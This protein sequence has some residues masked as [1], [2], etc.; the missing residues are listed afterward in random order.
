M[1][2]AIETQTE[3]GAALRFDGRVA[4]VTGAGHGLGRA[5]A[6]YLAQR[7][8]AVVVNDLGGH[9]DGSGAS[10]QAAD[11]V[12]AEILA[13]GGRAVASHD[14]VASETGP[15]AMV[16]TA[17]DQF[18]RL[19]I[20]VNNAGIEL[21]GPMIE[22]S[23]AAL[24]RM[25]DVHFFGTV[26]VCQAAWPHLVASGAG[27][28]VNTTSS[29]IFGMEERSAYAATKGAVLA[30][31]RT[32][33]IEA[34][35]VGI[36]VNCIAPAAGTRMVEASNTPELIRRI[37]RE[38]KPPALV[39]PAVALLAHESC[40]VTGETL[41]AGGGRVGRMT[42]SENTGYSAGSDAAG[43]SP[44]SLLAHWDQMMDSASAVIIDRLRFPAG[45]SPAAMAASGTP[46]AAGLA[47]T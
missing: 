41:S 7:G 46:A 24:R 45:Q 26:A 28:I 9:T 32:L 25:F 33:A 29:A 31:S 16:Q 39:A 4:L 19:D 36:K 40:P 37:M 27:R 13:Q 8:A 47:F 44:E 14:S 5:Y 20:V 15:Q 18:G 21:S 30:F 3:T 38:R 17:I 11:A 23:S 2:T 1:T 6:I 10:T 34:E 42:L 43:L 12:V 22:N 35:A